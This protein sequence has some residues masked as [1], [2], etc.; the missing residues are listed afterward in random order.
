M[1]SVCTCILCML[2]VYARIRVHVCLAMVLLAFLLVLT[3]LTLTFDPH[4]PCHGIRVPCRKGVKCGLHD[5]TSNM[6]ANYRTAIR[7]LRY[8]MGV[9][10]VG[11]LATV[12][13]GCVS[14]IGEYEERAVVYM[15]AT[16]VL[17]KVDY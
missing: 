11:F 12:R 8:I 2:C 13:H 5:H 14:D 4:K 9:L 15:V 16:P 1:Y 7:L 10:C 3:R 6:T 17:V